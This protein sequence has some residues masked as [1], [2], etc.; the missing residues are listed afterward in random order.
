MMSSGRIAEKYGCCKA[1]IL[2]RLNAAKINLR[3]AGVPRLKVSNEQLRKLYLDKKLSTWKIAELL[4]CGR[5]TIHR[6]LTRLGLARDISAA[7]IKYPRKP[8]SG[9]RKEKA[10]LLGFAIGD[11]RARKIGRKS[12]TVKIDCGSTKREQIE[13]IRNLFSRYG[14]VWI[15]KPTTAGKRQI[16]AFLDDSFGFLLDGRKKMDWAIQGDSFVPF[17]AGFTDAEGRVFITNGKAAFSIGNYDKDLL[18]LLRDGLLK[19]GIKPVYLYRARKKY[20]I[21]GGYR[22]RQLYWHL[23]IS[24]KEQLLKLF[25]MLGPHIRHRKRKRDIQKAL[26]N[27][28]SRNIRG[29]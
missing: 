2:K 8:F 13:L 23:K 24:T 10:Y 26:K 11:L 28:E 27:I 5:S 14:H 21:A 7:H 19:R 15:S 9:E 22:Q 1:T 16:E 25:N 17:L 29:R 6:K 3:L 18:G 12:G 20:A 4:K